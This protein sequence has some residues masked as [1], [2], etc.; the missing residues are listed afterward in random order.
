MGEE[1]TGDGVKEEDSPERREER[2]RHGVCS[3]VGWWAE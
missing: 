3:L 2:M 1:D